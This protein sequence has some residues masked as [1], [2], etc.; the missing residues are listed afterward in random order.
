VTTRLASGTLTGSLPK[1]Y[2]IGVILAAPSW[3]LILHTPR[4]LAPGDPHSRANLG[5]NAWLV[6]SLLVLGIHNL[7]LA[8]PGLLNLAYQR[9][10]GRMLGRAI[11]AAAVVVNAGLFVGSLVFLAS[12][13][14]F[15]EF[16]GLRQ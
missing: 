12:G 1:L 11:V 8:V 3:W 16:R 6:G 7:P 4:V 2:L 5:L 15:E 9:A 14:S 10:S 13:Q